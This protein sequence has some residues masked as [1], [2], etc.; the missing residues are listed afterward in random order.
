MLRIRP[1]IWYAGLALTLMVPGARAQSSAEIMAEIQELWE[2]LENLEKKLEASARE[3]A[4]A[5]STN[6]AAPE[7]EPAGVVHTGGPAV[8][9]TGLV[10]GYYSN[11]FNN[12]ADRVNQLR[13]FDESGKGFALNMAKLEF[14]APAQ[15]LGFRVD[16]M[17]GPAGSL[18]HEGLEPGRI[19]DFRFLQQ[20][21]LTYQTPQGITLDFGKFGTIAGLEVAET[22][23]NWNYSRGILWGWAEPFYHLG[24]RLSAP[25]SDEFTGRVMLVNGWNNSV[26]NNSGKSLGYQG[27]WAPNDKFSLVGS[28]IHGPEKDDLNEGY[29]NY[30]SFNSSITPNDHV[31]VMFNVDGGWENFADPLS[32]TPLSGNDKWYGFGAYLRLAMN[33]QWAFSQ[34]YEW[35]NDEDAWATGTAQTL[36]EYT[37]TLEFKPRHDFI[38][39][40]EYRRDWSNANFFNRGNELASVK[41]QDTLLLGIVWVF[42]PPQ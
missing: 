37:A 40:L 29:R 2:R 14:E 31:A 23:L 28:F 1:A 9:F 30:Y 20:A 25:L 36:Q 32:A 34:R 39:R 7:Q 4:S 19:D 12:P 22:H 27:A 5:T 18:F 11:N 10:D 8:Q 42:G 41:D 16:L 3:P 17:L 6:S 26:D 15:P 13:F 38:T 35:F 33:Q 21:Y 24:A